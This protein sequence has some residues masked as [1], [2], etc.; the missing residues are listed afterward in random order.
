[1]QILQA[2]KFQLIPKASTAATMRRF[3]GCCR[4]LWNRALALEK[5]TYASEG[6]RLGYYKLAGL[7]KEW[8]REESTSFLAE[9]HSQVAQQTLMDLDRSY[10]NFFE[11]RAASPKFKKK[12]VHDS[13]R[14]PQGFKV[15]ENN[16]RIFLPKIGWVRYR[17]SRTIIGTPK[18]I[19]VS[20]KAGKWYVSIQTERE[21]ADPVHPSTTAVGIDMGCV[22]FATISDGTY[23][24]PLN[25]FRKHE[26]KLVKLQRKLSKMQKFSNNWQKQKRKLQRHH[27]KIA[28]VRN[29]FL[30]KLS[31]TISKNHAMAV[32][33]DLQ[34]RNMSRS[35]S[36]SIEQPGRNVR[37]KSMLN[38]SILDQGWHE[39]RRQLAYKLAWRGGML[40]VIPPQY[41][42]QTCS[43]C[44]C[45]DRN[46]RISQSVFR[47]TSCGF[48]I[49]ADLNAALNIL[50]AGHAVSA[51]G[52]ERAQ[53]AAMNQEPAYSAA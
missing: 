3:A 36:G 33:E 43:N 10:K 8:K 31:T 44:G 12:G 24:D 52:A 38:K 37:A 23:I 32:M 14:Y 30:H 34:V 22:H 15:D 20:L 46:S 1:M 4:F 47:C 11:H 27:R 19:T 48:E 21:I 49:N 13:F 42:S 35:A 51:C 40:L 18:Q 6:K 7:L 39:F 17:N 16:S 26:A 50:A 25:S 28:N 9:V 2:F 29:D 41:T 5:E 45:I 53:A